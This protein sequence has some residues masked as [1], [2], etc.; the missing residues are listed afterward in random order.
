MARTNKSNSPFPAM[1]WNV[2]KY[3]KD[4]RTGALQ[5]VKRSRYVQSLFNMGWRNEQE[6]REH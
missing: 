5:P 1:R 2:N 3:R 4:R 6:S